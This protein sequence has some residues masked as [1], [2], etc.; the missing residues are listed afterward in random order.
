MVLANNFTWVRCE[1]YTWRFLRTEIF[2]ILNKCHIDGRPPTEMVDVLQFQR[3]DSGQQ[4]WLMIRLVEVE[5]VK[6]V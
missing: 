6:A 4:S 3:Q 1:I 5:G 2:H